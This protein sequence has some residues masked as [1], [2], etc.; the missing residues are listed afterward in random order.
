MNTLPK[1]VRGILLTGVCLLTS[2]CLVWRY[3]ETPPVSG[4][5]VD[6]RS[7]L[8]V[9]GARAVIVER[10][11]VMAPTD[12]AGRFAL[13]GTY[14]WVFCPILPGD[15]WPGGTLLVEAE[16]YGS[17]ERAVCAFGDGRVELNPP[18]E[19]ARRRR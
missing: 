7:K 8:P 13:P 2:G 1:L 10:P 16:G 5:V 19:L 11:E 6:A 17:S 12:G 9:A 14:R 4:V 18:M 15:Y 3:A